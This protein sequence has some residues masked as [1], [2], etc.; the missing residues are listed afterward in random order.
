MLH[1][2][3]DN[4]VKARAIAALQV[5]GLSASDAARLLFHRIAAD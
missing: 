1:V 4:E 3:I 2:R 5:M